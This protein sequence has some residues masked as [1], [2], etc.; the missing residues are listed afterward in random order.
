ME[1]AA[2]GEYPNGAKF[3]REEIIATPVLM[4]VYET[5]DLEQYGGFGE[6]ASA[7]LVESWAHGAM[8]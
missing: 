3:S 6:F 1:G 7:F 8:S 2:D 4:R 5:N